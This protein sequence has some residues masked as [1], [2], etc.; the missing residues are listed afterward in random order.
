M[1]IQLANGQEYLNDYIMKL[2]EVSTDDTYGYTEKNPIKVGGMATRASNELKFLNA[3]QGP[4]GEKI[5][6][7]RL[8]SCCS[9]KTKNALIGK[10]GLLDKYEITYAG[11]DKPTILYINA[12]DFE[13]PMCPKG[14]TFIRL[15]NLPEIK[16]VP[17]DS[18]KKTTICDNEN[19]YVVDDFLLKELI[20]DDY[21]EPDNYPEYKGGIEK[22]KEYFKENPL[23]DNRAG[24]MIFRVS[25]S[26]I[27]NC[28]GQPGDFAII[29]KGKGDLEELANQ[30]LEVVNN[31][32]I[33]WLPATV[34]KN[35]VDC[36]QV[37]S[38]TVLG[39]QLD[40][41]SYKIKK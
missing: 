33:D 13:S 21:Q 36:H 1:A 2:D 28:N 35:P 24:E 26:F 20:G 30:V 29:S 19:I 22:L 39:G 34:K 23:T 31:M 17:T 16:T 37:L 40:K 4:N 6:F 15:D 25:I 18:L 11:L 10:T 7:N 3:L 27:V 41:V 9:F 38:F 14:L 12:Y 8:G 32:P 5:K